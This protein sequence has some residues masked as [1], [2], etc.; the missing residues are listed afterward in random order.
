[1]VKVVLVRPLLGLLVLLGS[2][3]GHAPR[4][5]TGV[6]LAIPTSSTIEPP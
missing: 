2:M 1:M 3:L 6:E 4:R 5:L